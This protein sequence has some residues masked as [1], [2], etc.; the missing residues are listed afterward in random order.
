[1]AER[2]CSI[3]GCD[4]PPKARGWCGKH[5]TRWHKWGDPLAVHKKGAAATPEAEA[6]RRRKIG[7]ASRGRMLGP[8]SKETRRKISETLT[9]RPLSDEHKRAISLANQAVRDKAAATSRDQWEKWRE[10]RSLAAPGYFGLHTR[11]RKLRG[12]ACNYQCVECGGRARHW[13][14]VHGTDGT[15]LIN[16][17]RPMCVPCH[18][19]SDEVAT[20]GDE[21]R[22]PGDRTAAAKLAWSRRSPDQ[23]REI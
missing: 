10:E 7:E 18:F 9:G 2:T 6:E 21:A 4:R 8:P 16:H 15:D 17:Y 13:A 22:E 19:A 23:R 20:K 1:M 11:V 3:D 12:S 5:W 14:T